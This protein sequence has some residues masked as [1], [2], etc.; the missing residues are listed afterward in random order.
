MKLSNAEKLILTMLADVHEKLGIKEAD[1]TLIKEAIY[2]DNTWALT[3]ELTGIVG[4][5]PDPTPPAVKEVLEILSMWAEIERSAG[6][7]SVT[8]VTALKAQGIT[9]RFPGFDGNNESEQFSI[10][11]MLIKHM[12]RFSEFEQRDLNSHHETLDTYRAMLAEWSGMRRSIGDTG[13]SAVDMK[14]V[15]GAGR[16]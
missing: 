12:G 4:D 2:S 5:S 1:T 16:D 11:T 3:F 8:D 15:L 9:P 13:L 7:L 10:A 14:R 6:V